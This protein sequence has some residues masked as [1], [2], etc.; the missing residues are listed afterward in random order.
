M[1]N[2]ISPEILRTDQG[3]AHGGDQPLNLRKRASSFGRNYRDNSLSTSRRSSM[4]ILERDRD[5]ERR[6][7]R[8]KAQS[9]GP[10]E[11]L[12]GWWKMKWWRDGKG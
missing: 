4:P 10:Q 5:R 11:A 6:R 8:S 1:E 7:Q 3:D 12:G 9:R 2:E